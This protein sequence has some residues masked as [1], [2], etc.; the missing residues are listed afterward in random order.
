VAAVAQAPARRLGGRWRVGSRGRAILV[1][2]VAVVM[3][4]MVVM[5]PRGRLGAPCAC[6]RARAAGCSCRRC[7]YRRRGE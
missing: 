7:T 1:V 4:M 3:V 2:V 5:P 6:T